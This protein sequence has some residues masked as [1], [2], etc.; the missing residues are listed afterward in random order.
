M[1]K[2]GFDFVH[3]V[4][5]ELKKNESSEISWSKASLST[6]SEAR[7]PQNQNQ[8]KIIEKSSK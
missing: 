5:A 7:P 4:P 1:T 3:G 8:Q 2:W 6:F